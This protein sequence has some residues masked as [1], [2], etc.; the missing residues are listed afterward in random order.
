[1]TFLDDSNEI[2]RCDFLAEGGESVVYRLLVKD[3]RCAEGTRWIC[4]KVQENPNEGPSLFKIDLANS[5]KIFSLS[6]ELDSRGIHQLRVL[7]YDIFEDKETLFQDLPQVLQECLYKASP[8]MYQMMSRRARVGVYATPYLPEHLH[9]GE[10]VEQ[11]VQQER[12]SRTGRN[13]DQR[14]KIVVWKIL[15]MIY[16]IRKAFPA[17]R[18][19]DLYRNVLVWQDVTETSEFH[20][21]VEVEGKTMKFR[22]NFHGVN[23]SVTLIDFAFSSFSVEKPNPL[24]NDPL[25]MAAGISSDYNPKYDHHCLLNYLFSF[26]LGQGYSN[27]FVSFMKFVK[28]VIH[29]DLLGV[30]YYMGNQEPENAIAQGSNQCVNYALSAFPYMVTASMKIP[31]P[32]EPWDASVVKQAIDAFEENDILGFYQH[33]DQNVRALFKA[34]YP[35]QDLPL[36]VFNLFPKDERVQPLENVLL[37]PYFSDLFE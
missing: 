6:E 18:H 8:N 28:S 2:L 29:T 25:L 3:T 4:I 5:L 9:L 17:F 16:L 11:I 1:M 7:E 32:N 34:K 12:H 19:N 10:L 26:I 31:A 15:Y 35:T 23:T 14:L 24:L 21:V 36:G 27:R 20:E 37:S 30:G 13:E 22:T 33:L